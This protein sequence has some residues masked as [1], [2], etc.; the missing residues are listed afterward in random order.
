MYSSLVL[1]QIAERAGEDGFLEAWELMSLDLKADLAVLS[2]CETGRGRLGRGEGVIGLSWALFIAGVPSTIVSQWKVR[3]DST[4]DLMIEV[5][6]R[7][8]KYFVHGIG[9]KDVASA[10]RSAAL[11]IKSDTRYRHPF[12]WA[13]F[14]V[15]GDPY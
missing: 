1:A 14:I 4:A 15:V 8:S 3:S 13:G 12:H 6:R 11:K 5:H 7:L 10:L 2:A 9:S